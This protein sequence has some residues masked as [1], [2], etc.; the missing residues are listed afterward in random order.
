MQVA[1]GFVG[2]YAPCGLSPQIDGMPVIQKK[3]SVSKETKGY[4]FRDT[5]LFDNFNYPLVCHI[6]S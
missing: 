2:N 1:L 6:I 4:I 5:T 3:P